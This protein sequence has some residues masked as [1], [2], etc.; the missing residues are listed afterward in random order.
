MSG[1]DA[2]VQSVSEYRVA[3][4]CGVEILA[5]LGPRRGG[6]RSDLAGLHDPARPLDLDEFFPS[7]ATP[8][9]SRESLR[10]QLLVVQ[11]RGEF[12]SLDKVTLKDLHRDELS[13]KIELLITRRENPDLDPSPCDLYLIFRFDSSDDPLKS[14]ALDLVLRNFDSVGNETAPPA[15]GS[16]QSLHLEFTD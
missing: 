11:P 4:R 6:A 9:I 5:V 1:F 13:L 3:G 7:G 10:H 14:L 8:R 12:F 2:V 15:E 16:R